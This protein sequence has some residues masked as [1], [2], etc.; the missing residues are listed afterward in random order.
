MSGYDM[1]E[2]GAIDTWGVAEGTGKRFVDGE[3]AQYLGMSVNSTEPGESS[4]FWHRHSRF[5]E[6]YVFL[7]G[8]GQM[9]L[10]DEV[11]DVHP[12]TVVRVAPE[13]WRAVH[14]A[15]DAGRPLKWLCLRGGGDSLAGIGRDGELDKERIFP[16]NA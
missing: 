6:L 7:D 8:R 4:P 3:S 12:G 15:A 11:V 5:E 1:Y 2:A 14:S 9:A 10:D 13:T 16:W